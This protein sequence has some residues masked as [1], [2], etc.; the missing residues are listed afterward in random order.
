MPVTFEH[1]LLILSLLL[2]V[3]LVGGKTSY[4]FGVPVL[5]FFLAVG[6]LAGSE[7]IGGIEF[8]SPAVAKSLG[9]VALNFILF[10][11]GL[12]TNWKAIKPV[13]WQGVSLSTLSVLLTAVLVGVFIWLL[14]DFTIYEGLLLGSIVSSTDSAA[15][16]SILRSKNLSLKGHLRPILE[17]ESGS[18]DPMAYVLTITF[19]MLITTPEMGLGVTIFLFLK[20][21]ILGLIFGF[22]VG[23]V[24]KKIIN[25]IRLDYEGMYPVLMI[26]LMFFTFSFTDFIGG[27]GFLAIYLTAV[28]LG[29]Q[30]IIHKQQ[31]IKWFDGFAWLMQIV[32]FL[33]LGLL[34]FPSSLVTVAGIGLLLS[35]F[36]MFVA[37]PISVFVGLSFFKMPMRHRWFVSW[38][39]LR[40]AVPIVFATY[41][42][43]AGLEI[44]ET[45]FNIVFFVSLTSLFFQGTTL[46]R[47]AK[48]LGLLED[49]TPDAVLPLMLAENENAR[50]KLTEIVLS[51]DSF[52]INRRIVDLD[53]PKDILITL[54]YRNGKYII[55]NGA[56]ILEDGDTLFLLSEDSKGIERAFYDDDD[57]DE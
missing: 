32:L 16:F 46:S 52:A 48:W 28:Y 12:D 47:V 35:L 57:K 5:I 3:S 26:V 7:G 8:N 19:L 45:I 9:I 6:M 36:M 41:P 15:V 14:T 42:M 11:G 22:I 44:A 18:N 49:E 54:I 31:I 51:D 38:I 34:V 37:R 43:I 23:W 40:G 20:Q 50:S 2:F 24:G 25:N 10:S 55:P 13:L 39:G 30:D 56:T 33:T 4:R 17:L 27:N 21:I 53:I 1:A 29:N